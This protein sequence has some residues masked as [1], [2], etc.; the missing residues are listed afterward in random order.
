MEVLTHAPMPCA[1]PGVTTFELLTFHTFKVG[2][3]KLQPFEL[4]ISGTFELEPLRSGQRGRGRDLSG[5]PSPGTA[6]NWT[7]AAAPCLRR[8]R[9]LSRTIW[10]RLEEILSAFREALQLLTRDGCCHQLRVFC[11]V[12]V[13][14]LVAICTTNCDPCTHPWNLRSQE[15]GTSRPKAELQRMSKCHG[16][17]SFLPALAM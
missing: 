7:E 17:R 2:A 14:V 16:L 11:C 10:L 5:D 3:C 6:T 15:P 4:S 9:V 8:T 13:C 12:C 1:F